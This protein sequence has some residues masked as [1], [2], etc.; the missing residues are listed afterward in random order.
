MSFDDRIQLTPVERHGLFLVR[1]HFEKLLQRVGGGI[2]VCQT[3]RAMGLEHQR[4]QYQ[5]MINKRTVHWR[6]NRCRE[7][8]M[9]RRGDA[10]D[11]VSVS[12]H[13]LYCPKMPTMLSSRE[14]F[15]KKIIKSQRKELPS[16]GLLQGKKRIAFSE[17]L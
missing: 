13:F 11:S 8:R 10:F 2:D 6:G 15:L 17:S 16:D 12:S 14:E 9:C 3:L 5:E 1:P 4:V 7:R